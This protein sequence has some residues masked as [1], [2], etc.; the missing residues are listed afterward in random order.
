MTPPTTLREL[1]VYIETVI[2]YMQTINKRNR[3]NIHKW[4]KCNPNYKWQ[5][6]LVTQLNIINDWTQ[7]VT[8]KFEGTGNH[9]RIYNKNKGENTSS[10]IL[11]TQNRTRWTRQG[12]TSPKF[13]Y[14]DSLAQS[15][16]HFLLNW[17]V[18]GSNPSQVQ[19]VTIIMWG[20]RPS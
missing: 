16:E 3:I 9:P 6:W 20:A 15:V 13:N 11:Q 5:T 4:I 12:R 7:H 8:I 14:L 18:Q 1:Y 10:S 2:L 17:E 19:W